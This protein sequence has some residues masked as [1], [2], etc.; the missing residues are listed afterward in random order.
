[1]SPDHDKLFDLHN[2][3][4]LHLGSHV[5]LWTDGGHPEEKY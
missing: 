1:M 2:I 4:V 5:V 3:K